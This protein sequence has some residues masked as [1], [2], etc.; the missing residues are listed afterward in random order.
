MVVCVHLDKIILSVRALT[1]VG[2][3]DGGSKNNTAS[4]EGSK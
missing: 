2:G 1:E 3:L 4:T